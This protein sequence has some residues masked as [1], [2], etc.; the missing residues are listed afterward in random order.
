MQA[1]IWYKH[2]FRHYNIIIFNSGNIKKLQIS[3]NLIY[4]R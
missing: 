1:E 2:N 4:G 3:I